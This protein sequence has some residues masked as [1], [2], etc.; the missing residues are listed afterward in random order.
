LDRLWGREWI[1]KFDL[2]K[3]QK[4]VREGLE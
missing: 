1:G 4:R 3:A 2:K